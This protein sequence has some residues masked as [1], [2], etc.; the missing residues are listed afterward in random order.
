MKNN[1][2]LLVRILAFLVDI[3]IVSFV[4]ALISMP[5]IDQ[6]NSQKIVMRLLK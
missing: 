4:A 6:D 3:F 5:F 2:G 1:A